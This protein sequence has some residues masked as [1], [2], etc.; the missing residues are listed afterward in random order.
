M[1][2]LHEFFPPRRHLWKNAL[3]EVSAEPPRGGQFPWGVM[4][5]HSGLGMS[6]NLT[7]VGLSHWNLEGACYHS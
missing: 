5:T 6:E 2:V 4:W 7:F 3:M 1:L